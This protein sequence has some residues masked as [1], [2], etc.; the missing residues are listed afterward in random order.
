MTGCT[1]FAFLS[2]IPYYCD[3][4]RGIFQ[5][6]LHSAEIHNKTDVVFFLYE[7]FPVEKVFTVR[8]K[9]LT[10]YIRMVKQINLSSSRINK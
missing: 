2:V 9:V 10:K 8:K 7:R 4:Y 5:I 1:V 6:N 3:N